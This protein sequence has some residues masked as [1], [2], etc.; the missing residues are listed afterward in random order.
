MRTM[1]SI[2]KVMMIQSNYDTETHRGIA[3]GASELGW[4]LNVSMMNAFQIPRQ[5]KGDGIICSLDNNKQLEQFVQNARL[6][7]VDLSEWRTDLHLP[8]VSADN[9]RIGQLAAEHFTAFGHR[10]FAYISSQENPV[11]EARYES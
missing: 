6:P 7:C 1:P 2:K 9:K 8:R 5:W 11:S 3:R 4:H 10:S